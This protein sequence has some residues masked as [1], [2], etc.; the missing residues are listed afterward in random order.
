MSIQD[1]EDSVKQEGLD[2]YNR[3]SKEQQLLVFFAIVSKL[4]YA[5][6][7]NDSS[8]RS[9]LYQEFGFDESSYIMAQMSGFL[10]VHNA[11][12]DSK[13]RIDD[14]Q[15]LLKDYG[16]DVSQEEILKKLNS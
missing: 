2:E 9:V 8:Y 12:W 7:D 4:K 13:N 6:L 5:D 10:E 1:Q 11:F 15:K 14:M 3:L 16:I